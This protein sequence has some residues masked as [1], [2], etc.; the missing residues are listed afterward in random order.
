MGK[1]KKKKKKIRPSTSSFAALILF[2]PKKDRGLRMC[3]DYRALNNIT[4]K[5]RYPIPRADDLIGQLRGAW[6]F[7]NI[8]IRKGYHQIRIAEAD[9][10]KTAFRTHYGSYEYTVMSF[11]LRNT[12]STFQRT[13]NEVFRSLL[14][15]SFIVY[16]DD[17]LV[18]CTSREQ[19]L[20]D[21]EAVFTLCDQHRLII[22]GS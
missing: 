9:I 21:L 20:T 8:D 13:M 3:I 5:S 17:I 4:I 19:H 16:P 22:K 18:Y 6:I 2:T 7:S 14:D 1:K 10:P 11:G 15:K 12:P